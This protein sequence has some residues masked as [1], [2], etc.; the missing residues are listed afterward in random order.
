MEGIVD[1]PQIIIII[2]EKCENE[3]C[4]ELENNN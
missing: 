3:L 1:K 2:K 4:M